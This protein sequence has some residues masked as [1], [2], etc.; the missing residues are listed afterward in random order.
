MTLP[1]PGF[2]DERFLTHRL[3]STSAGGVAGAAV[4]GALCVYRLW[5]DE[6][7]SWDLFAVLATMVV[8]KLALMLWYRSRD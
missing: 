4:A 2:V 1:R 3:R 7:Y 6:V 8:V 5:F